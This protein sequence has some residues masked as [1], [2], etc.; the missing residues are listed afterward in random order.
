MSFNITFFIGVMSFSFAFFGRQGFS[1]VRFLRFLTNYN[2][3]SI[4][5]MNHIFMLNNP[6]CSNNK[7]LREKSNQKPAPHAVVTLSQVGSKY[8]GPPRQTFQ[9]LGY[10]IEAQDS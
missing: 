1:F 5:N 8:P 7:I 3:S 2:L 4:A 6:F 9:P 10:S